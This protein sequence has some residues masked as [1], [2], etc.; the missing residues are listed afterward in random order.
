LDAGLDLGR[1]R[2]T[3]NDEGQFLAAAIG[4]DHPALLLRRRRIRLPPPGF[5]SSQPTAFLHR[6]VSGQKMFVEFRE[7]VEHQPGHIPARLYPEHPGL[8]AAPDQ[9]PGLT[10]PTRRRLD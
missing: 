2:L 6:H 10:G 3:A 8:D 1:R 7:P 5:A 9:Q 4:L